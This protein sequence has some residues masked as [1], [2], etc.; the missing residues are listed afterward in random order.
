MKFKPS[1]KIATILYVAVLLTT[2][3]RPSAPQ[4]P[5]DATIE[6]NIFIDEYNDTNTGCSLREAITA[7]ITN[8]S[9]GGCAAGS[10]A[11]DTITLPAGTYTLTISGIE[12]LNVQGDLDFTINMNHDG[13]EGPL[14]ILGLGSGATVDAG[15]E[16]GINDRVFDIFGNMTVSLENLTVTGGKTPGS[17]TSAAFGA[18]IRNDGDLTLKN[19]TVTL[20]TAGDG[21]SGGGGGGI[22]NFESLTLNDSM[23]SYNHAG[24]GIG[25]GASGAGGGA[26]GGIFSNGSTLS[27]SNSMIMNNTAGD[28]E[29]NTDSG[30]G[31][32]GGGIAT[33]GGI[34]TITDSTIQGNT[35]GAGGASTLAGSGGN[36]GGF[37]GT[38]L[39]TITGS[40][41]SGNSAGL[42]GGFGGGD[43]GG[44]YTSGSVTIINSTVSGNQSGS[45]LGAD[46]YA[47]D[48]G[49]IVSGSMVILR[50]ST[51]YN[52][53]TGSAA[54]GGRG[55]G[56]YGQGNHYFTLGS[57]I[58]A[59]NSAPGGGY[60]DCFTFG[61]VISEDYNLVGDNF[62]GCTFDDPSSHSLLGVPGFTLPALADNGGPTWTH[63]LPAGNPAIDAGNPAS[64]L[65][66]DQRGYFRPVDGDAI[67]GALSD[68]GAYEYFSFPLSIFSWLPLI[69]K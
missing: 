52:N 15:G 64:S 67:P 35:A 37:A 22:A 4:A 16:G 11:L 25:G 36:G 65:C 14:K 8:V 61:T 41:I 44:M 7:S 20:N 59:G 34:I 2:A 28:G 68:I 42:G 6:V 63:A 69:T 48:G 13:E 40:T 26:G 39:I 3:M 30:S 17:G 21:N 5:R 23:V 12:N 57:T 55:G 10:A 60:P 1:I 45:N 24:D 56:L 18:G 38:G 33:Y 53:H 29:D 19:V 51:V 54:N 27:I 58:V 66:H 32:P 49:G 47:G 50:H 62:V 46:K 43:G 31:G 9:F